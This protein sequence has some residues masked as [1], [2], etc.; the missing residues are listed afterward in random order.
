MN[1]IFS[2]IWN[3]S[4]GGWVVASEHSR[5]HGKTGSGSRGAL[6]LLAGTLL[7]GAVYAAD[8]PTG[9]SIKLGSGSISQPNSQQLNIQQSTSKLAIDWQSFDVGA[10]S[11]VTFQQPNSSA[12]A[13]NRVVGTNGSQILGQLT[14]NGRVFLVNPN[15][16]LFGSNAQ[17]NVGGLIAST[18]DLS[19]TDFAS[20]R[21]RFQGGDAP[22]SVVN[23]GTITANGGAVALLGGKVSNQGYI[24]ANLGSVTLAAGKAITV[25]FAGDGLLNVQLTSAAS[26]ALVYNDGLLQATGGQVVLA[27]QNSNAL[28]GTVVNN[29]GAIEALSLANQTGKII[30]SGGSQGTVQVD[31]WLSSSGAGNANAG[32]IRIQ[33]QN[34]NLNA[35]LDNNN[36]SAGNGGTVQVV[37]DKLLQFNGQID[38]SSSNGLGGSVITRGGQLQVGSN[39][40]VDARSSGDQ[41]GSWQLAADQLTVGTAGGELSAAFI[42]NSLRTSNIELLSQKGD[43]N[44]NSDISWS[45]VNNQLT[46]SAQN[47]VLLNAN[48]RASGRNAGIAFNTGASGDYKLAQGKSVTLSGSG[49]RFALNGDAYTVVQNVDQ[50]Q[51]IEQNLSGR[52]VLGNAID[53]SA[54]ANWNGGQGF[55]SL[56]QSGSPGDV[57]FSGVFSGLGNTVNNLSIHTADVY[58]VG[59]FGVSSGHIRN[60]GVLNS[61]IVGSALNNGKAW[62]VGGVIG[63]NKGLVEN[64]Y[65]SG[66]VATDYIQQQ[67]GGL[68]GYNEGTV[69]NSYSS[70]TVLSK[71]SDH[72]G[73]GSVGGLV[74]NNAGVIS[75]AYAT[76][77]VV[78]FGFL[79][80]LVG[81]NGVSAKLVNTYATGYVNSSFRAGGL[82]G[83]NDGAIESS[84]ATGQVQGESDTGGLVGSNGI[85]ATITNTYATGKVVHAGYYSGAGGLVGDNQGQISFSYATGDV[86]GYVDDNVGGLVGANAGTLNTTSAS[87]NV[88]AGGHQGGYTYGGSA[89]GLVGNNYVYGD[90]LAFVDGKWIY[91]V[92][93]GSINNSSASGTVLGKT[94]Y[95][96]GGLVGRNV[97][98]I[99]ASIASGAV[100]GIGSPTLGSLIGSNYQRWENS[101]LGSGSSSVTQSSSSSTVNGNQ[102]PQIGLSQDALIW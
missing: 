68:I 74:G 52:Y 5:R 67:L 71:W 82:V 72:G 27:A 93:V 20:N 35:Q 23:D 7:S 34:I 91:A 48:L 62:Y 47:N 87:G 64:V 1:K 36:Y 89:G 15:G 32:D 14:S 22:A 85:K 60:V 3:T 26:N 53:A 31:G 76:G 30:L 98:S 40:G 33:G 25:D 11:K 61:D 88:T 96:A 39:A 59:L 6:A 54:T 17:V 56:G 65:S 79:G 18:L 73:V 28:L 24:Q 69:R 102:G 84:Y 75:D 21:F 66:Q 94:G 90:H 51:A 42:S 100:T 43:L 38:V 83:Q 9:G 92:T 13:L 10:D 58:N 86:N 97:G 45:T 77:A 80:G 16:V 19:V 46:L 44:L 63:R 78:G 41:N 8:L 81:Y 29:Q 99:N 2:L 95:V 70:S 37:A 50:L 101:E 55:R 12:I 4:I 49:A 57:V